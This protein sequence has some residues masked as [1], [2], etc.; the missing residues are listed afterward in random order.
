MKFAYPLFPSSLSVTAFILYISASHNNNLMCTHAAFVSNPIPTINRVSVNKSYSHLKAKKSDEDDKEDQKMPSWWIPSQQP[1]SATRRERL[2]RMNEEM[3]RFA[4]GIELQNLRSDI[5]ALKDN[6]RWALATDDI[7]C[8]IDLTAAIQE[9]EDR[10]PE[11]VYKKALQNIADANDMSVSKKYSVISK[12]TKEALSARNYIPRLNMEGLWLGSFGGAGSQ[13]VNVT[14]TGDTLIAT[15]VTEDDW[16]PRGEVVFRSDLGPKLLAADK[17]SKQLRPIALSGSAASKFGT[18]YLERYGGEGIVS[19]D[20]SRNEKFVEGQL[21]M[22]DG[23]FSF[24]W[25]PSK[26]HVFFSR[27]NPELTIHMLRDTISVEDE[28]QNMR[29]HL[30]KCFDKNIETAFMRPRTNERPEPFRRILREGDLDA[31]KKQSTSL[32][33]L[34]PKK[35][36]EGYSKF[37]FW[38]FHKWKNYI[39]NVLNGKTDFNNA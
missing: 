25:L 31:A 16:I 13:L 36:N 4:Q 3:L 39:D 18:Q 24:L 2:V 1:E 17:M 26:Q 27:P 10:D 28:V 22:F 38:A 34:L 33:T 8:I 30:T 11:L 21:I 35:E 29:E 14:Y 19:E 6:L 37:S 15:K 23:Y 5:S 7:Q 32:E 9:A 20:G 12:N